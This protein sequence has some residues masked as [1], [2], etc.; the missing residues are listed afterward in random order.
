MEWNMPQENLPLMPSGLQAT[1]DMNEPL[2]RIRARCPQDRI[3][4]QLVAIQTAQVEQQKSLDFIKKLRCLHYTDSPRQFNTNRRRARSTRP[5]LR[6]RTIN[7]FKEPGYIAL[8]YAWRPPPEELG[9]PEG[10]YIVESVASSRAKPSS[11]RDTVFIRMKKYMDYVSADYLW[12]DKHCIDQKDGEAKE[13][14]MQ[15]MDRVY[16]L[17]EYPVALLARPVKTPD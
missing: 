10:G 14:G 3:T 6:L 7:A 16:S 17:S 9:V 8:S 2:V 11:V 4:T 1:D 13:I 5:A 12:I 15:A